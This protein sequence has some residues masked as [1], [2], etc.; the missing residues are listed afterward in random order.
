MVFKEGVY[1]GKGLEFKGWNSEGGLY[2]PDR[3]EI[4]KGKFAFT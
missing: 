4:P 1:G 2:S 3:L